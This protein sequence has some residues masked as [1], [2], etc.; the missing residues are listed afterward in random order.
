M[1]AGITIEDI[2]AAMSNE[3]DADKQEEMSKMLFDCLD[4][5]HT[6]NLD[7]TEMMVVVEAFWKTM[8][9]QMKSTMKQN[10]M[11]VNEAKDEWGW[12]FFD[13]LD[14]NG[15][16]K[17]TFDEWNSKFFEWHTRNNKGSQAQ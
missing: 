6:G 5:N 16:N 3:K 4:S 1:G 11:S 15:D 13:S 17:V 2:N 12:E 7:R 10:G 14:L 9:P 8:T